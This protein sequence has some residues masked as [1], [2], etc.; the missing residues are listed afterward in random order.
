MIKE[1]NKVIKKTFQ[2]AVVSTKM[3][4]TAVIRVDRVKV[5]PKYG[6]RIKVSKRYKVHDPQNKCQVG[7]V[8]IFQ[9]CRPLS[10]EKRWRLIKKLD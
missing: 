8:V 4:K 10:K 5:H 3:D 2:G 6:K 9:E 7:D 1:K